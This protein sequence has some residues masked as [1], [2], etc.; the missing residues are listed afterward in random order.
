MYISFLL[1]CKKLPHTSWLK[2]TQ[3]C[4]L[5]VSVDWESGCEFAGRSAQ[6]FQADIKVPV[7]AENHVGPGALSQAQWLQGLQD[8]GPQPLGCPLLSAAGPPPQRGSLP[9]P[10]PDGGCLLLH[11]F[12]G[13]CLF[14][15]G[16][17]RAVSLWINSKSTDLD[18]NYIFKIPSPLSYNNTT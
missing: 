1:L 17:S 7:R 12:F 13:D 11:V 16:S 18:P 8:H 2:K 5:V 3:I 6:G 4:H 14:P 10:R 15:T 9:L